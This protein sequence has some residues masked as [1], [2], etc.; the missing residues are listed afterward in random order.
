M[1]ENKEIILAG[2]VSQNSLTQDKIRTFAVQ[3][4]DIFTVQIHKLSYQNLIKWV[5]A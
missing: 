5:F 3:V 2:Y 1:F 4:I